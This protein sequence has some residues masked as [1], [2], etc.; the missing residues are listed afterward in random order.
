MKIY[1]YIVKRDYGFA[2]NPF[3]G[4]CTL[5][6]CKPVIRKHAEIGDIIVGIGSGGKNSVYKNRMIFAMKISEVLTYDQYWN[7]I[8]FQK[9]KPIMS[10]SKK[11]MYGDN[12]YHTSFATGEIVQEYSHHS[13]PDGGTNLLNYNR[14]VPG[15]NVLI[16]NNYWYW[17]REA[18][19]IPS[20]LLKLAAVKRGHRVFENAAFVSEVDKWLNELNY[21]GYIG[22]PCKFSSDYQWYDGRK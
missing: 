22:K 13:Y 11:Q 20:Q 21:S 12:I 18:I 15:E 16:S 19:K 10:V 14:D 5:A 9:K 7:D 2:P 3:Y 17:G 6:T 8:R 1:S 4:Y